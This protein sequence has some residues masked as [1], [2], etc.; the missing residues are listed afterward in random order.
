MPVFTD[1][2]NNK[3]MSLQ[4]RRF[5]Y[6]FGEWPH[7]L[8]RMCGDAF[9]QEATIGSMVVS[10]FVIAV[11]TVWPVVLCLDHSIGNIV[12]AK[13]CNPEPDEATKCV[14][15]SSFTVCGRATN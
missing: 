8:W 11:G 7:N 6:G 5:G 15:P 10:P 9:F 2:C 4:D 3:K 1:S 13:W 14:S 12:Q